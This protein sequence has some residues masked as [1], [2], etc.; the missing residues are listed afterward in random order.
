MAVFEN[1][2]G[3]SHN[4]S[5]IP[6]DKRFGPTL[7]LGPVSALGL[8]ITGDRIKNAIDDAIIAPASRVIKSAASTKQ[9]LRIFGTRAH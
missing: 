9:M 7:D 5:P 4:L 8:W 6:D 2:I 1:F 3:E